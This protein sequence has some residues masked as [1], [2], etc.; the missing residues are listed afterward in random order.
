MF[1]GICEDSVI[2][3]ENLEFESSHEGGDTVPVT[4]SSHHLVPLSSL[5]ISPK[6]AKMNDMLTFSPSAYVTCVFYS[7]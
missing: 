5:R 3:V 2:S 4:Q 7:F 6:L 1:F